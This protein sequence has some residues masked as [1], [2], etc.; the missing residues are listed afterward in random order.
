MLGKIKKIRADFSENMLNSGYFITIVHKN[1]SNLLTAPSPESISPVSLCQWVILTYVF[2]LYVSNHGIRGDVYSQNN[3]LVICS[4]Y[5]LLE[6]VEICK[7]AASVCRLELEVL[8]TIGHK[9]SS[10][11]Q[12]TNKQI[13]KNI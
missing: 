8:Y 7:S 13:N 12:E 11:Q 4:A 5:R 10:K 2:R 6:N 9:F 3:P 1:S